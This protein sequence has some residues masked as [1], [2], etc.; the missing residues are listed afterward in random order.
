MRK[1]TEFRG[2]FNYYLKRNTRIFNTTE[3]QVHLY[4][5]NTEVSET[6][7]ILATFIYCSAQEN[8]RSALRKVRK[9]NKCSK[10]RNEETAQMIQ[11]ERTFQ[12]FS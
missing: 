10:I 9:I 3:A 1:S 7:S 6:T 2:T 8:Q 12:I 5:V 11:E 4:L